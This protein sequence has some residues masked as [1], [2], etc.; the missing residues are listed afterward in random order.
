MDEFFQAPP[1]LGNQYESDAL[2]RHWLTAALPADVLRQIEPGLHRLGE[3]A[4]SDMLAMAADAEA[5][6]PRHIPYDAWGRR[7]D[8]IKTARGWRDLLDVA[9]EEGIVAIAY[10]REHGMYSRVH[11]FARL[12]LYNPSS[13]IASC[14]LSMTDGAAR[15]IELFG[16]EML[17]RDVLPRLVSRDPVA[18][19]T[20]GQW[21]TERTGGSDVRASRTVARA[22]GNGW[23]LHGTKWFTS[24]T[25]GEVAI[26]LARI[27]E[28]G[29]RDEDL[30]LFYLKLRDD[31]GRLNNIFVHRLKDKLGT[32]AL[33]TAELTLQ[34]TPATLLGERG[35]GVAQIS[36]ILNITRLYNAAAA[37][38]FMRRGIALAHDYAGKRHAFGKLLREQ[39]LHA[40]TLADLD[41][42]HAGAFHLVFEMAR[43]LGRDECGAAS[44]A[45]KGLLRLMTPVVKLYTAKQAI[46]VASEVLE[47][48]GGQGYI[49]D[50]GLPALLRNC[51]VLSIWEGT[52]NVLALDVLR[53]LKRPE[54]LQYLIEDSRRRLNKTA[55]IGDD[56]RGQLQQRVGAMAARGEALAAMTA[57]EQ[58][59]GA[60]RFAYGL[61]QGYA[62]VLLAESVAHAEGAEA[63]AMAEMLRRWLRKPAEGS[64]PGHS[65]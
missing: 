48:F 22:D 36:T 18:F 2:L 6:P 49:E 24:A 56:L 4:V 20:G 15:V 23:R 61:G 16:D 9:A 11:Q 34:G 44:D 41:A 64:F 53:A 5:N 47:C 60:R 8:A 17:K 35:R 51:Q 30:S 29:R 63:D 14:P 39:P 25:T 3:R 45:E 33:P 10:E 42:G 38:S 54:L 28:E 27:E 57:E 13:A 26:T 31:H 19:W 1:E 58:Q 62:A 43:L 50:T 52:T 32:R 37:V 21:M 46:A 12:Y 7:I 65:C 40:E 55:P 59:A